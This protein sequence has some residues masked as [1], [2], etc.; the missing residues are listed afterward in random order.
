MPGGVA[1]SKTDGLRK[2]EPHPVAPLASGPDLAQRFWV[3]GILG[4]QEAGK[5]EWIRCSAGISR[6]RL[7]THVGH[8]GWRRGNGQSYRDAGPFS[9]SR[10]RGDCRAQ[11]RCCGATVGKGR[12]DRVGSRV[13][14]VGGVR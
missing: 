6:L 10:K 3:D 11:R 9:G 12:T 13:R 4:G 2:H 7:I 5:V 1:R 8:S 14:G